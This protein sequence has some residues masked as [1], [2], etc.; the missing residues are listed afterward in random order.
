MRGAVVLTLL[1]SLTPLFA[2][3]VIFYQD[4]DHGPLTVCGSGWAA[5]L[6]TSPEG[7]VPGRFGKAYRMERQRTNLLSP[8]QASF[9]TPLSGVEAGPEAK[10]ALTSAAA[11]FGKQ[12]LSATV[13]KPGLVWKLS[14]LPLALKSYN[15]PNKVFVFSAYL[16]SD[17]PARVRLSLTDLGET[18]DWRAKIE[19]D[20]A[21]ALAKDPNAKPKPV[22]ETVATP[23][24]M[25]LSSQWQRVSAVLEI[26]VRRAEQS[27]VPSLE[28]LDGPAATII[29]DGLQLEQAAL[30][31]LSNTEPTSWIPGGE[32]RGPSWL[33][34]E[35]SETGFDGQA[36]T[37]SLWVKPLP[38]ECGGTR[39]VAAM[40]A[41]GTGWFAPIWSVSATSWYAT[42]GNK[43]GY[44][45]G[46]FHT[47]LEPKLLE[48]GQYEGWHHL[49]L[50]WDDQGAAGFLDGKQIGKCAVVP[51]VPAPG[52][53]IRLGG[54]FLERTSMT[55]D[56]DEV[57]IYNRRLQDTEIASLASASASA[58][59]TMPQTLLRRP[60]RTVFL[61]S[62][63]EATI[64][65][66][67][68]PYGVKPEQCTVAARIP[69]VRATASGKPTPSKP[70]PLKLQPWLAEPGTY[71]L[72]IQVGPTR[73][74]DTIRIFEE[75]QGREF[76]I[77]GWGSDTD[78]KERNLNAAVGAGTG[79][80][81]SQLE[82]GMFAH[83]RIDVR[84]G[85]PHPWSPETRAKAPAI[86]R[87]V[88]RQAMAWPH[89]V[90]CL[91]NSEVGDPPFPQGQPWFDQ[92]LNQET[93]LSAIPPYIARDPMHVAPPAEADKLFPPVIP[94]DNPQLKFLS[95]W[96]E[97]GQ[98]YWLLGNLLADQMR[99]AGL[100]CKY[101]SDQP[102]ALTQFEK[103]DMVDYWVYPRSPHGL[104]A[105]LSQASTMA[106]L[107]DKPF[108]AM[109]GTC[110]WDDGNGLWVTDT[111]G[112]RKV[113]C[114]SPDCF[115]E[116]LWIA[117]ASPCA[118]M[119]L[120][121]LGER[122]TGV[123]DKACDDVMTQTYAQIQP[124]GTLVGGLPT[125]QA[126]VA[127]L[128]TDGLYFTQ[129][130]VYDDWA[131][132]WT[133]R[134]ASRTLAKYRVPFDWLTDEHVKA[135]WL[136][137]YDTIIVPGAW[138]L[139]QSTYDA[140]VKAAKSG[141]KIVTDKIMRAEIPGMVRL[142]ISQQRDLDAAAA[143]YAAWAQSYQPTRPPFA[144]V[145]P[146]DK[147]FLYTRELAA[148]GSRYLFIVNDNREPGPQYDRW[149]VELGAVDGPGPLRDKGL[150]QEVTVTIPAGFAVYDVLK[151]E[152]VKSVQTANS[153]T[154]RVQLD[155]GAAAVIAC[156]PQPLASLKLT[157]PSKLTAGTTTDL[158]VKVLDKQG[159]PA[160]GRQMV[161]VTVTTPGGAR[162]E[163]VQRYQRVTN[164]QHTIP[165]RLP[166]TAQKGTWK[167]SVREWTSGLVAETTIDVTAG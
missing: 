108:Q 166:L 2:S 83:T 99:A 153:Q 15:K 90:A 49:A 106:R 156:L 43:S 95:W 25:T 144:T 64:P 11:R 165:L 3:D 139:P 158:T 54:S 50:T 160:Q 40:M 127:L 69:A 23:H 150:P 74:T 126:T 117:A 96:R 122:H 146:A 75:P 86:A 18:G 103:M 32:T 46:V 152:P 131:R 129:P 55:G 154:L 149:K 155:P 136:S 36:G 30:Y 70:L 58:A 97:R 10:L 88:A 38:S 45:Q 164:G 62:E 125:Q 12:T 35:A 147:V 60:A 29:A 140:L 87:R 159:K 6:P 148:N 56:L 39:N 44:K 28:A 161:E 41:V 145:A 100:K 48:P 137:R 84:D 34:I 68:V 89:V 138:C 53:L 16:R 109:P 47:N 128:D 163:G 4:F 115:R 142:N 94:D 17:K 59:A 79:F 157:A 111:D 24:E 92:W 93:G 107:V 91:V 104:V 81:Q 71:P 135:G 66:Q 67:T 37:I 105:R 98:G 80:L 52:S 112:K 26:D 82:Q 134:T 7:F 78:L 19:K 22:L 63:P 5:D 167:V 113:L 116:N 119:G 110:Y 133:I 8:T 21:A 124:I 114:L 57:I 132:Y 162:Y 51:G 102:E 42:D 72:E 31:P 120:Y 151:H 118:S 130:G 85:I 143:E 77:Y 13:A 1:L 20:N 27:L 121:G 65:L 76:I 141:T 14:P 101:Y 123:Y 9:E 73:V 61:R 33:E